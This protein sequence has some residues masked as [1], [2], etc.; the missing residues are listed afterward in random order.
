M[1]Y[2]FVNMRI[3]DLGTNV[4]IMLQRQQQLQAQMELLYNRVFEYMEEG[5][6]Q[7]KAAAAAKKNE[8]QQRAEARAEAALKRAAAAEARAAAAE[9]RAAAAE[10]RAAAADG[11]TAAAEQ[12]ATKLEESQR[13]ITGWLHKAY[14]TIQN[15]NASMKNRVNALELRHTEHREAQSSDREL[16]REQLQ[17][18]SVAVHSVV[19]EQREV[20][21]QLT[22]IQQQRKPTT[23]SK[24]S[25]SIHQTSSCSSDE[26]DQAQ[27]V[28]NKYVSK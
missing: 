27:K 26:H 8:R 20:S 17:M 12:A 22:E 11:R 21:Q 23:K 16:M 13:E 2:D 25:K 7:S 18:L 1:S 5:Q 14:G 19:C 10:E 15:K 9:G 3:D 6:L 4:W 24:T 28:T